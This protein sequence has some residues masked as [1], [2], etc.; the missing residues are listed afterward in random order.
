MLKS[1]LNG[2]K[3]GE[4]GEIEIRVSISDREEIAEKLN[5]C[6]VRSIVDINRSIGVSNTTENQLIRASSTFD[7]TSVN[8]QYLKMCLME[9]HDKRD[10]EFISPRILLDAWPIISTHVCRIINQSLKESVPNDWKVTMVVSVPKVI[11][12]KKAEDFRPTNMLPTLEKLIETVVKN[13]LI[14]YIVENNLLSKFQ[15]VYRARHSCETALNLVLAKWREIKENGD[16][17]SAV[18]LDLKRAFETIDRKRLLAKLSAFGFTARVVKWFEE[19][20]KDRSQQTKVNG[21]T[22]NRERNDLGVPQ[23][24][25]LGAILFILYINDM[26]TKL[27][28]AFINLFADDTLIYLHGKN[29]DVMRDRMNCELER[30]NQWL[31]QNKLKLNASKTKIMVIKS[32]STKMP[33]NSIVMDGEVI[34]MEYEFKY[35]GVMIDYKLNFKANVDYICKKVAK[36][37]GVLSRLARYITFGARMSIYKSIIAPH[38]DYCAMLLYLGDGASFGRLQKLQ[39]RAMRAI[40]KCKKLTPI[41]AML[42][43]LKLLNVKQ[44]VH[45]TTIKFI[46]KLRNGHSPDYL[47]EMVT[48]NGD[49]HHYPTRSRENFWITCKR[50]R[51]AYNSLFHKGLIQFNSLPNDLKSENSEGTF[52]RKLKVFV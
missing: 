17:I 26:P 40:L 18:F 33:L 12:P 3:S 4:I 32:T 44:R 25:V 22:S 11:K 1:L 50:S 51:S 31:K 30:I 21:Y 9:M 49:V 39:N 41:R 7:F 27:H 16:D 28:S 20:L 19:Y 8:A 46:Y 24:S 23:G 43:A 52:K 10:T 13:Q 14:E 5:E 29:L 45:E 48:Y 37:V 15:S 35:L 36:K 47:N 6:Y 34:G 38:F 2:K 42:D